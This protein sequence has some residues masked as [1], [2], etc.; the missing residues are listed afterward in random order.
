MNLEAIKRRSQTVASRLD[1]P[2]LRA[3]QQSDNLDARAFDTIDHDKRRA[4][5]HQ[6]AGA[7]QSP[8]PSHL[9]VL[10]QHIYLVLNL[11]VLANGG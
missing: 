1:R 4:A 3:V 10:H 9:R 5:D 7:F 8:W 2:L 11:L 6:L